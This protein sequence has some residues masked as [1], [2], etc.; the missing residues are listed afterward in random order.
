[1]ER[2]LS[3]RKKERTENG[4]SLWEQEI[5]YVLWGQSRGNTKGCVAAPAVGE[6]VLLKVAR[7][8]S[9][10]VGGSVCQDHVKKF[11]IAIAVA[12]ELDGAYFVE[13]GLS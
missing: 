2:P 4:H 1:M 13:K 5:V 6:S 8:V 3:L 7:A 12:A 11:G 9:S 10:K